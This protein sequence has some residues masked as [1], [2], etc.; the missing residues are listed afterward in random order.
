MAYRNYVAG[1]IVIAMKGALKESGRICPEK[2]CS[3]I[4]LSMAERLAVSIA[5]FM[6]F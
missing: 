6:M 3:H 2:S 4:R 5:V 1:R